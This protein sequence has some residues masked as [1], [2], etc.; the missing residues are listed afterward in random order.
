MDARL[1]YYCEENHVVVLS[2]D[3]YLCLQGWGDAVFCPVCRKVMSLLP[4]EW[5][6]LVLRGG[7]GQTET[8][9]YQRQFEEV[10]VWHEER[11]GRGCE[12]L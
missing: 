12:T 4:E 3:Q 10:R 8:W 5:N 9:E 11:K 1:V 6:N 7:I 2:M